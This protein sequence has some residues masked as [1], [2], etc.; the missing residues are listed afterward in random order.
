MNDLQ[1]SVET[2]VQSGPE[3][4]LTLFAGIMELASTVVRAIEAIA[5]AAVREWDK[6]EHKH[7]RGE[8]LSAYKVRRSWKKS[9]VSPLLSLEVTKAAQIK[10]ARLSGK[11]R[12]VVRPHEPL[13]D[14]VLRNIGVF[15]ILFGGKALPDQR[16]R[17]FWQWPLHE[18][19]VEAL[20]RGEH[21]RAKH[22]GRR[23]AARAA[24]ADVAEALGVSCSKVHQICG[25][26][27][28]APS[29]DDDRPAATIAEFE[30]WML[31]GRV[32]RL[33]F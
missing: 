18:I 1:P 10:I 4:A 25:K 16:R 8:L 7:N 29:G 21:L 27:R 28:A 20:Y 14:R 17:A 3:Q 23:D 12:P 32:E 5:Q 2:R 22:N 13:A 15:A 30:T 9:D 26:V 33:I 6:A 11:G 19:Y 31:T 24:E